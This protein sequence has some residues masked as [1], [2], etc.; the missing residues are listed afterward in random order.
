[1]RIRNP[2]LPRHPHPRPSWRP[3]A[4]RALAVGIRQATLELP[5]RWPS[6]P[7]C[8]AILGGVCWVGVFWWLMR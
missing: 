6:G 3:I 2:H 5:R 7:L 1:M 4:R 8:A